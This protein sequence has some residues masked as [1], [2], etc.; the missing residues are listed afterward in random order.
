MTGQRDK[1]QW[2]TIAAISGVV[3]LL[4]GCSP[5]ERTYDDC[6]LNHVKQGMSNQAVVTVRQACRNKYEK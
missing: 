3:A 5:S 6:I 1:L 4:V 2:L